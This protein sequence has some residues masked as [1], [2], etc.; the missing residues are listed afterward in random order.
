M[1][2]LLKLTWLAAFAVMALVSSCDKDEVNVTEDVE[3]YVN[4]AVFDMEERGNLGKFGCYEFVF[5]VTLAF[6]DSTSTEVDDYEA[7]R[8]AIGD[9]K[10]ANPEAE[11]RPS[12]A[13]PVELTNED[14]EILSVANSEELREIAKEC[15]RDF[16]KR[17]RGKRG[18]HRGGKC[19]KL[20]Y[21]ITLTLPD[22]STLT[23]DT[24]RDLKQQ[25]R[26][27]KAD[28]PDAEERPEILFPIQV[29]YRD[30]SVVD[31]ADLDALKLLKED[32]ANDEDDD[33]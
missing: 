26:A 23:G 20:V 9:W 16:F 3:F 5:P 14:G 7:L 1:N 28:N 21:P 29:Q 27:W 2:K 8:T 17:K 33:E 25:V 22:G 15:R 31:V 18:K 19:F 32:C 6:P 13:F 24:A 10:E 30:S 11:D 12:F 4:S